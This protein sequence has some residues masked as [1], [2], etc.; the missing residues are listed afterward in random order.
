ML[1]N[2]N[3]CYGY[4]LLFILPIAPNFAVGELHF[5]NRVTVFSYRIK[6]CVSQQVQR[7]S[8][9]SVF[10]SALLR[11][12][13]PPSV[14]SLLPEYKHSYREI[15]FSGA[16]TAPSPVARSPYLR[17]YFF[18]IQLFITEAEVSQSANVGLT[19]DGAPLLSDPVSICIKQELHNNNSIFSS[20]RCSPSLFS[21]SLRTAGMLAAEILCDSELVNEYTG[22][23]YGILRI[24]HPFC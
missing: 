15:T 13:Q 23:K 11:F 5:Q 8:L 1:I 9:L 7:S 12:W 22:S 19:E 6:L 10:Q 14:I 21:T 17:F 24:H 3:L 20:V 2:R 4:S 18:L 16:P